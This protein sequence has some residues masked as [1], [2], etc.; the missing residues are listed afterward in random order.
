MPSIQGRMLQRS[1]R[2]SMGGNTAN[3]H[4]MIEVLSLIQIFNHIAFLEIW[5]DELCL[6]ACI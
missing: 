5:D 6:S 1:V 2:G 4:F 3:G